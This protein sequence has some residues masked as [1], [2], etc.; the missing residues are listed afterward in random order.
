MA[1]NYTQRNIQGTAARVDSIPSPVGGWNARDSIANMSVTDAVTLENWFP[2]VSNCVLRGGYTRYSTGL[3]GQV[4]TLIEYNGGATEKLFAVVANGNIY[5]VTAGGAVGA[6][7]ATGLTNGRW[8]YGNITTTAGSYIYAVNGLDS[9]LLY[10]GSTWLSVTGVSAPFAIT[11][12][13]TS[14][15]DNVCLFKN[16]VWFLQKDT[17]KAWY[18]PTSAVGGAANALDLS[19]VARLGGYLVAIGTWTLD[20][21]YGADD[22]LVF[23]TSRGEVI[24]YRGTDPASAS[25]W[26]LSGIWAVG[27]PVGKRCLLKYG[28]DLLMLTQDGLYPLASY[29]QSSRLDPRVALSDKIQG[30]FVAATQTYGSVF[31]WQVVSVPKYNTL[32]VNVPINASSAQ[33]QQYAMNSI[34]TSWCNFTGW[35]ANC[36]G[37][38]ADNPYFGGNGFV[39]RA[40]DPGY[41]DNSAN[42]ETNAIQ[43]FNYF[44]SRGTQ[45][46][47]TRARPALFTDGSPSIFVGVN[48]DFDTSDTTAALSFSP[49]SAGV[50]NTG[51]WDVSVWGSDLQITN[52]WQGITG[53]G[54][55][56]A[57]HLKS[58]SA[59]LQIEWAATDVV[60]QKGWAGV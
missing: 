37:R 42:I 5:D 8:E 11:G 56:A 20:A 7:V 52:N 43:A 38:Y 12:V 44:G 22:N 49:N 35:G 46:Y 26:A 54:Y 31:G 1:R 32:F 60:Y 21:G 19:S 47:F 25:T 34:T 24:V 17:L 59:G 6:A 45:K 10:D 16:R 18:L 57:V 33:Q 41:E 14:T 48:V 28:G 39:G 4:E 9:A 29:L 58:S 36:W 55:C 13:T 30:A 40:F 23:V 51:T 50:W 53:I 27:D 3:G 15:L 2:N